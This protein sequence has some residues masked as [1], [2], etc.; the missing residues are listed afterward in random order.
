MD[1]GTIVGILGAFG[2]V[3]FAITLGGSLGSFIDAVSI[4]IVCGGTVGVT[5]VNY[6]L[7]D[8]LNVF[9]IL[10]KTF[11]SK[12]SKP[13]DLVDKIVEL[14]QIVRKDGIL[15]LEE[16]IDEIEDDF[17]RKGVQMAIDGQ[18]AGD[19]EDILYMEMDKLEA[20]HKHGADIFLAIGTFAPA[21][22]MI[23]TLVGL[24]LMLQNMED[25]SSIGPAM[26]VALLTTFYG[27]MIANIF[28][29][30]MSGKL[31]AR[32]KEELLNY[33]ICISGV[34]SILAGSNPRIVEEKLFGFLPPSERKSVFE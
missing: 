10:I 32:S 26:S 31:K 9:K 21:M 11:V 28:F 13:K 18:E 6:P 1:I 27:A 33:E 16:R 8:V 14:A 24:V 20:R 7:P 22:G 34:L 30:P 17:L 29:L 19:I 3:I 15:A 2:L 12:L 4:V 5:L 23:G 25:P